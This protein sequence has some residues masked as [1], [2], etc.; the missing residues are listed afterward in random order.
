MSARQR[1]APA[2]G[3]VRRLFL[4]SG[5]SCSRITYGLLSHANNGISS[6]VG[7]RTPAAA[8]SGSVSSGPAGVRLACGL[9]V[10][11]GPAR[12][13][14]RAP[15]TGRAVRDADTGAGGRRAAALLRHRA[16]D[17]GR[18]RDGARL[19]RVRPRAAA[20]APYHRVR[21]AHLRH[22]PA[23]AA[24]H[25]G[26]GRR[27]AGA[28]G[29]DRRSIRQPGRRWSTQRQFVA[30]AS[31]ELRT[32]LARS[33]TMLEVAL[34]DPGADAESLRAACRRV[35]VAGA[36]QERLIEA[37][38]TLARGQRGLARRGPSTWPRSP[39]TCSPARGE[40]VAARG[41]KMEVTLEPGLLAG[42]RRSPSAAWPTS[43]TTPCGTTCP[44]APSGSRPGPSR[45]GGPD[46]G[47]HRPGNPAGGG[48]PPAG[49]LRARRNRAVAAGSVRPPADEGLGLGLSIVQAIATAHGADL[50]VA[51]PPRAAAWLRSLPSP[52]P[53]GVV[54]PGSGRRGA[55]RRR[56][57]PGGGCPALTE[58][59][60]G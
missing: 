28:R 5:A 23:R 33:Q 32:P 31:H 60:P 52:P 41:L 7:R 51:P 54:S 6:G 4:A 37:L 8:N 29:H 56:S 27:R 48:R 12:R 59:S 20:A 18:G 40:Q 13:P 19:V 39:A 17:H 9:P 1:P 58:Y 15:G 25:R 38:L 43:S 11:A 42:D 30:N 3:A 2:H 26:P 45:S 49:P 10:T 16:R 46:G 24:C 44:A 50:T 57:G 53:A 55:G 35:L 14:G 47:Q 36:E 34:R 21:A 22:E